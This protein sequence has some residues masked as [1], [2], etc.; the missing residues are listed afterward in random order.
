[1][2]AFTVP[3]LPPPPPLRA[4]L[5]VGGGG[6]RRAAAAGAGPARRP[7]RT[8]APAAA[9]S[10]GWLGARAPAADGRRVAAPLSSRVAAPSFAR[11]ARGDGVFMTGGG[12]GGGGDGGGGGGGAPPA[13]EFIRLEAFLKA[14]SVAPTGGQAKL[15]I[16]SGGVV[17]NGLT[18]LRRGRKL[19]G[20]DVVEV[21]EEG[22]R[23][24]VE[25]DSDGGGGEGGTM[26]SGGEGSLTRGPRM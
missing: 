5:R 1:M 4:P 14:Q 15:L 13:G 24:T 23:M 12:G 6:P 22:V 18:E 21:E 16:R 11:A 19:R 25:F 7:A 8:A 10:S 20:G 3:P 26:A 2:M 17:V 9:T